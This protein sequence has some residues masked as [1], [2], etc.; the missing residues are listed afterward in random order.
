MALRTPFI[1]RLSCGS[2]T[3]SGVRPCPLS[4]RHR[5]FTNTLRSLQF[6]ENQIMSNH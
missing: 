4:R 1:L 6:Q 3:Q 2:K 5:Y